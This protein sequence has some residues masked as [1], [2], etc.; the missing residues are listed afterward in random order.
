M[1]KKI[2]IRVTDEEMEIIKDKASKAEAPVSTYMRELALGQRAV[3]G[4]TIWDRLIAA[5]YGDEELLWE[6]MVKH[7]GT[8]STKEMVKIMMLGNKGV[9]GTLKHR[10]SG[11]L[12][13][14]KSD[15][16]PIDDSYTMDWTVLLTRGDKEKRVLLEEVKGY[17]EGDVIR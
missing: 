4:E 15:Q 7:F 8:Q 2:E 1:S 16:F 5:A 13:G 3:A 6:L 17:E 10:Y 9:E 11:W 12:V 14:P